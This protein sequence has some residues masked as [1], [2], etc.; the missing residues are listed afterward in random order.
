MSE[1]SS[2]F[3][4]ELVGETWDRTYTAE[5][6]ANY[7]GSFIGN[8]VFPNPSTNLQ[9]V[10]N[11]DMTITVKEGKAWINGYMYHNDSDLILSVDPADGVLKRID[12]IVV[13][14]D[15][16]NRVISCKVKK[17]TFASSP[18]APTLQRDMDI[19]ELGIA[20][21]LI[22]N[23]VISIIQ[24]KITDTRL[25]TDLCGIVTQTVNEIDT[26]ELYN[27]LQAYIDERG[28]D[29][30]LWVDTATTQW[31]I[32]FN[33][34]FDTIKGI[35]SGDIAGNL[36]NRIIILENTVNNLELTATNVTIADTGNK[37]TATNVEGALLEAINTSRR[38]KTSILEQK[39]EIDNLKQSVSDGKSVVASAI[40]DK[41]VPTLATDTFQ[42]MAT[43]ITNIKKVPIGWDLE[44]IGEVVGSNINENDAIVW[45]QY[46]DWESG[47]EMLLE[48]PSN[49]F[50]T[51]KNIA[52]SPDG[53]FIVVSN[54]QTGISTRM[55]RRD[56]DSFTLTN[57]T[58]NFGSTT[59]SYCADFFKSGEQLAVSSGTTPYIKIFDI[60][61][62]NFVEVPQTITGVALNGGSKYVR[63]SNDNNMIV[64]LLSGIS[65]SILLRVPNSVNTWKG[66]TVPS[67]N[68]V[69]LTRIAIH[70]GNNIIAI[71]GRYSDS[72]G[73][74]GVSIMTVSGETVTRIQ[75]FTNTYETT[76]LEFSPDGKYL[77][78]TYSTNTV[79]VYV[80]NESTGLW[81]KLPALS[82]ALSS[83]ATSCAFSHDG[84]YLTASIAST[85]Y[86][87]TY[88]IG[89]GDTFTKIPNPTELLTS[90][91]RCMAFS[92]DTEHLYVGGDFPS[93]FRTYRTTS[94]NI[95][96]KY[97]VP[98]FALNRLDN[99]KIGVAMESK[100]V[101]EQINVN[102]F[103][104]LN[105]L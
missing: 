45:Q 59:Y 99:K 93:R 36:A 63:C 42:T 69:N 84:M 4:A 28:Q 73:S 34:W 39:V 91:C 74:G 86:L 105:I 20:D 13:K 89:D 87:I 15:F 16:T 56:G 52:V 97:N 41:G 79:D 51:I 40:T 80:M 32:E 9:I 92:P 11:G 43:N 50:P 23:G 94:K 47:I 17:G 65:W 68:L 55:Y 30:A 102:L 29:V 5:D 96:S 53:K 70:P 81:Q 77:A 104:K 83:G 8:G 101:G 10:A 95:V 3:N 24:S 67:A 14:L 60:D 88:K 25:N 37:F 38:N 62:E 19:Y 64:S 61:G 71:G 48:P 103:P 44:D 76:G 18:I 85:P 22:D 6:Y 54:E 100:T 66:I 78:L 12:R 90:Y 57:F 49:G 21:I 75:T 58:I 98:N 1:K 2:F 82:P 33:T 35:L 72:N 27:K 31:G 46:G 26:N 7:F